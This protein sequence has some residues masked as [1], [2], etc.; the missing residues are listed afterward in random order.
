[1]TRNRPAFQRPLARWAAP[2]LSPGAGLQWTVRGIPRAYPQT[3][4]AG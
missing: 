3:L 2:S 1:M 4:P